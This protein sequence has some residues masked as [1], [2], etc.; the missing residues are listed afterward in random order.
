[1]TRSSCKVNKEDKRKRHGEG[2]KWKKFPQ[3]IIN[4]TLKFYKKQKKKSESIREDVSVEK[5][6]GRGGG[7]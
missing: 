6:G 3:N 5:R 4:D 2:K 1:M 7:G